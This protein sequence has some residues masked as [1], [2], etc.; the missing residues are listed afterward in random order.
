MLVSICLTGIRSMDEIWIKTGTCGRKLALVRGAG[1]ETQSTLPLSEDLGLLQ[2][3]SGKNT[4][5]IPKCKRSEMTL[6]QSK[7]KQEERS[8]SW[9]T[10]KL[11]RRRAPAST[12][13]NGITKNQNALLPSLRLSKAAVLLLLVVPVLLLLPFLS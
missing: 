6:T 9:D 1:T 10:M 11:Q 7:M 4:I 12:L 8:M 13:K 5:H 2:T 3:M